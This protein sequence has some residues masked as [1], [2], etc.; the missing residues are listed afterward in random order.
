MSAGGPREFN[1]TAIADSFVVG[2]RLTAGRLCG[3]P[4]VHA[5]RDRRRKR[6]TGITRSSITGRRCRTIRTAPTTRSPTSA[7]PRRRR[8][9]RGPRAEGGRRRP[10]R[11]GAARIPARV[12]ARL[13]QP[14]G[15]G[16]G[17]GVENMLRD[18]LEAARPRPEIERLREEARKCRPSR[19]CRRPRRSGRCAFQNAN[20]RDVL[21]FI[22]ERPASTSSSIAT[23]RSHDLDQRRRRDAGAG[24]AAD[25]ADEPDVLQGAERSHHPRLQDT[26]AKRTQ[27]E[28]QV[29]RTFFLS[30]AD[31]TEMLQLLNGII[32]VAG[33]RCSRSSSPT[34]RPTR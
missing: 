14:A 6:A 33:W 4:L 11:R 9:A 12:G 17:G 20:A 30:H 21:N 32:R 16:E 22:G 18:R 8:R 29:V 23:P 24:A 34:R 7:R 19:S 5:R 25:H 15:R 2:W 10:A 31:A 13:Q 1:A 26:T 28:D 3:E 27:F